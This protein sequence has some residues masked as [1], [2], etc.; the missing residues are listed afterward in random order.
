MIGT[1]KMHVAKFL[2]RNY[3]KTHVVNAREIFPDLITFIEEDEG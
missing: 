1:N 2:E 3:L